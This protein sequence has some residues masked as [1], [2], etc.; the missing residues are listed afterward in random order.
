LREHLAALGIGTDVHYPLPDHRQ[1]AFAGTTSPTLPVSEA[2]AREI[3]TLP[4]FPEMTDV[5]VTAVVE[6][7]NS[8]PVAL[9]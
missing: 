9:P 8:W 4:C 1:P 2:A 6:A 3:T 7:V 5:E